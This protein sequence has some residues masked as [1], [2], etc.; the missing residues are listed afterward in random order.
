[1]LKHTCRCGSFVRLF[2]RLFVCVSLSLV[3]AHFFLCFANA[4]LH[5][6]A[7]HKIVVHHN[8]LCMQIYTPENCL[9]FISLCLSHLL[10]K[11]FCFCVCGV[12]AAGPFAIRFH[13]ANCVYSEYS[14]FSFGRRRRW[15]WRCYYFVWFFFFIIAFWT[16]LVDDDDACC[17]RWFDCSAPFFAARWLVSLPS[18]L[19]NSSTSNCVCRCFCCCSSLAKDI[20]KHSLHSQFRLLWFT[21]V[22]T[23]H[24]PFISISISSWCLKAKKG[25]KSRSA[26]DIILFSISSCLLSSFLLLLLTKKENIY[27]WAHMANK[28]LSKITNWLKLTR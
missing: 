11:F 28:Y 25:K 15:W 5:L 9:V 12:W 2:G 1:M 14:S 3:V 24:H 21:C 17:C 26:V 6:L 10:S 22:V 27:S 13:F 16:S 4:R 23:H 19:S 18:V 20:H 7:P 8:I